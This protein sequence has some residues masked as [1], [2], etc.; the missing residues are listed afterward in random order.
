M[1]RRRAFLLA[2]LALS[3][4]APAGAVA[5]VQ[6][7]RTLAY[8]KGAG[9]PAD[10]RES[11][12]LQTEIPQ[13]V[14]EYAADVQLVDGSVS[15]S[16]GR[17]LSLEIS[18]VHAPGGG[19]WSGPKWVEV[20][21]KLYERGKLVGSFRAKRYSLGG[22]FG[23]FLGNCSILERCAKA[24]GLDIANWLNDPAMNAEIGDAR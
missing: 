8:A 2:P 5:S 6:V 24:L 14:A 12:N 15:S 18:D 23:P 19:F 3:L 11:C 7:S 20:L 13:Y 1:H 4:V 17:A 22:V 21:G 10:V 9:V 16:G